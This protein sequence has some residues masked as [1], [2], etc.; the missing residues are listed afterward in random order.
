MKL[1]IFDLDDTLV[2]FAATRQLAHGRLAELLL[3]EGIDST[4]FLQAC[5]DVDR[6]LFSQFEQGRLSREQY[7]Q[8]RFAEPF[9]RLGLSPREGLVAQLNQLFMTCVNDSPQLYDDVWPAL[10]RVR[11]AGL[12]IAILTNGPSDG[13]RRKLKATGLGERVDHVAIGE[14]LGIS[15]PHAAAFHA[16]VDRFGVDR[17]E[18]LMVG[19]SPTLDYDG[20][21][22]AGIQALLLDRDGCCAGAGR[23]S[24]RSL[25]EIGTGPAPQ[26]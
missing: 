8:R 10:D 3:G 1:V 21:L 22:A 4:A 17:A 16:V 13:Q 5:T 24:I 7:R 14:E 26:A 2:N 15:K 12:R 9:D 20:A 11:A 23:R 6:P 19:D 18:A 25:L